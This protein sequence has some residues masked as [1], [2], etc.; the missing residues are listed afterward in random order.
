[1]V[2]INYTM[3]IESSRKSESFLYSPILKE[4]SQVLILKHGSPGIE[5]IEIM[6]Y[7]KIN[8]SIT[9][10]LIPNGFDNH[11]YSGL[12]KPLGFQEPGAADY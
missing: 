12:F 2:I 8:T 10:M 11:I 5:L 1:M 9:D 4:P 7:W 6:V 3:P